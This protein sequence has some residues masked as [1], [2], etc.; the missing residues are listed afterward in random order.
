MIGVKHLIECHCTLKIYEGRDDHLYHKFVVYSKFDEGGRVIEKIAQCNNCRTL[1]KVYDICK[2]EIVRGGKDENKG[3]VDIEDI[4]LQ[5]SEKID[6]VLK[7]YDCDIATYEHVLDI[8]ENNCWD[9]KIILSREVVNAEYQVKVLHIL[10]ED[11]IK[12]TSEKIVDEIT[13]ERQL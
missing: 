4:S 12:I 9:E 3:M 2:S 10:S 5:L 13:I 1:H 8:I 7:K 6:R 11:K